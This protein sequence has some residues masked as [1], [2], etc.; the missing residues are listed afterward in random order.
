MFRLNG[1]KLKTT[2]NALSKDRVRDRLYD[3]MECKESDE[4]IIDDTKL[5]EY[6]NKKDH[7]S[8]LKDL[9]DMNSF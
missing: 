5:I 1:K 4:L 7:L 2:V 9:F 3:K 8:T 6:N